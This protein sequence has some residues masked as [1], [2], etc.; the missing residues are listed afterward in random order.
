[1]Q[2]V[3]EGGQQVERL[4]ETHSQ[5]AAMLQGPPLPQYLL[6]LWNK[7]PAIKAKKQVE[8]G[9]FVRAVVDWFKDDG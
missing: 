2:G 4:L 1:M 3:T 8:N 9:N 5:Q 7:S 6:D